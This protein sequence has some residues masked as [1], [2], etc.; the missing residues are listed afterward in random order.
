MDGVRADTGEDADVV[1]VLS[2][3]QVAFLLLA[4][5]GEVLM[6]GGSPAYLVLPILKATLLLVLAAKVVGGRRWAMIG[7]V[8]LESVTLTGFWV[9]MAAGMLP[10]LDFTVNLVTL[11]SNL[12]MPVAVITLCVIMISRRARRDPGSTRGPG[13]MHQ[14][15]PVRMV[16]PVQ[17]TPPAPQV[18]R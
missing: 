17:Q 13:L 11:I 15:G 9:Q 18:L 4:G 6:M 8:V 7:L 1:Y 5:V 2:L 14:A 10:W 3:L 16:G 12:G